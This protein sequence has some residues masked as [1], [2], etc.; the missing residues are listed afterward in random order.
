[1]SPHRGGSAHEITVI[2]TMR[3]CII[4]ESI[5]VNDE[6]NERMHAMGSHFG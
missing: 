6:G 2:E 1:M 5:G 3:T 4:A